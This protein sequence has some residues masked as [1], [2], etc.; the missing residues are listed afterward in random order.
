[1]PRI[2]S[3]ESELHF[4]V[5]AHFKGVQYFKALFKDLVGFLNEVILEVLSKFPQDLE[6]DAS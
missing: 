3:I 4:F 5:Q 6:E 1:M 2:T